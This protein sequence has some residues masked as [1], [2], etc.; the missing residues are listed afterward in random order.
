MSIGAK[1]YYKVNIGY[2]TLAVENKAFF[3][4]KS[5]IL[6]LVYREERELHKKFK[7]F[8]CFLPRFMRIQNRQAIIKV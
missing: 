3:L 4:L 2:K 8:V 5:S 7:G 1:F 6:R